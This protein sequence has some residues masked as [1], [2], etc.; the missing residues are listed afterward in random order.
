MAWEHDA[1]PIGEIHIIF[2][3]QYADAPAR[4]AATGFLAADVGK[5]ARQLDNNSFWVLVNHSPVTWAP[6]GGVHTHPA[7]EITDFAEA[8]QD[9]VGAMLADSAELD[10]TYDDA[11]NTATA[12]LKPTTVTAGD[13]TSANISVDAK[14][15]ITAAANGTGGGGDSTLTAAYASR[16]APSNDG[17][18]FFPTDGMVVERDTGAAYVPW[19]PIWPFTRPVNADFA[20]VNQDGAAVTE[21]RGGLYLLGTS[22]ASRLRIRTKAAPATPYAVTIGFEPDFQFTTLTGNFQNA[23]VLFREATTGKCVTF[24]VTPNDNINLLPALWVARFSDPNTHVS[25]QLVHRVSSLQ[26]GKSGLWWLRIQNDGTNLTFHV[27]SDGIHFRQVYTEGKAA[28]F[29][30]APDQ[31][32]FYVSNNGAAWTPAMFLVHWRQS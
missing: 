18:L 29:T 21:E 26:A 13:Y 1:A 22:T 32:G 19:G 10:Y 7:G 30:T 3:W 8:A 14:G 25:N 28:Y 2:N 9:V 12:A 6:F 4:T 17:N 27:S 24:G 5:A 23:G 11:A 31:V 20:W 15:R 16:P